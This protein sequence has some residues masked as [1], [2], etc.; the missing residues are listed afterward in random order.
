MKTRRRIGILGTFG[1][2]PY[3]GMA[4]MHCQFLAG[5]AGMGHDVFY[6]EATA[7]WPYDAAALAATDNPRYTLEY[8]Q[9]VLNRFGLGDRWAYR[10]TYANKGWSGPLRSSVID[11][12]QS[13][14][15]VFNISG[16]TRVE[17]L[18]VPCRCCHAPKGR[19]L[20]D[21]VS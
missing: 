11:L 20:D 9:R 19:D 4:W 1:N 12:L 15:A 6:V 3:A 18:G 5:L 21:G 16:A 17:D 10:A 8:S 7:E 2:L 14:D 13:A